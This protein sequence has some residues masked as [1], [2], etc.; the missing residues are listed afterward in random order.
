MVHRQI[1]TYPD[2]YNCQTKCMFAYVHQLG[3]A[4]LVEYTRPIRSAAV[5]TLVFC[6]LLVPLAANA[7]RRATDVHTSRC[8]Q[9]PEVPQS[10]LPLTLESP[11]HHFSF[12]QKP[13]LSSFKS[14]LSSLTCELKQLLVLGERLAAA[15]VRCASSTT[16]LLVFPCNLA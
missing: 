3:A 4:D 7:L 2:L 14:L 11:S 15:S 16:A 9:H 13:D 12:A 10:M 6:C 8:P 5:S 1:L